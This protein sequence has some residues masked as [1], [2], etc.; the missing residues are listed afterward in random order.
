MADAWLFVSSRSH[1]WQKVVTCWFFVCLELLISGLE[2]R[3]LPGSPLKF[4]YL[5]LEWRRAPKPHCSGKCSGSRGCRHRQGV[6]TSAF[7]PALQAGVTGSIP[8]TSVFSII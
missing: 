6:L 2:V 7:V 3:V 5:P 8:V 1:S 4:K